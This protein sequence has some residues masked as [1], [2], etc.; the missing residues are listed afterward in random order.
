[1]NIMCHQHHSKPIK[2]VVHNVAQTTMIGLQKKLVC[3]MVAEGKG[4]KQKHAFTM[5]QK[6]KGLICPKEASLSHTYIYIYR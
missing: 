4:L 6:K 1:M 2:L 3:L 5:L